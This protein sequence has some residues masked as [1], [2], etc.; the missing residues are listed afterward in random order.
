MGF[1]DHNH[2]DDPNVTTIHSDYPDNQAKDVR[3][4]I[5]W[6]A[7]KLTT[8]P[9]PTCIWSTLGQKGKLWLGTR[10]W[11]YSVL[12]VIQFLFR[13]G[14]EVKELRRKI[15]ISKGSYLNMKK[16]C[17]FVNKCECVV[18]YFKCMLAS[19]MTWMCGGV[20]TWQMPIICVGTAPCAIHILKNRKMMIMSKPLPI[21]FFWAGVYIFKRKLL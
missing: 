14:M 7:L 10:V 8:K 5:L 4:S 9:L 17:F 6:P 12:L 21:S 18:S 1:L 16:C 15:N 13:R 2:F 3:T 20:R 11:P 19:V